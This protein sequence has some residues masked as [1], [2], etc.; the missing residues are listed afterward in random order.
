MEV[1]NKSD[2]TWQK[3][4]KRRKEVNLSASDLLWG[5]VRSRERRIFKDAKVNRT[6][7]SGDHRKQQG[8]SWQMKSELESPREGGERERETSTY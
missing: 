3:F 2:V 7:R 6:K 8:A 5:K 4:V 1:G